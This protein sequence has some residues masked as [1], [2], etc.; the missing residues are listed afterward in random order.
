[1]VSTL[2]K[3][4]CDGTSPIQWTRL[5]LRRRG[6]LRISEE[7]QCRANT[8][9]PRFSH[10]PLKALEFPPRRWASRGGARQDSVPSNA[11]T[12]AS[13]RT[14]HHHGGLAMFG[15]G[16]RF[17]PRRFDNL[18]ESILGILHAFKRTNQ[19]RADSVTVECRRSPGSTVR[20]AEVDWGTLKGSGR[21]FGRP[22]RDRNQ[23]TFGFGNRRR[24]VHRRERRRSGVRLRKR[25][26]N[27]E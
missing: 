15:H 23:N 4:S 5:R 26:L 25:Q 20:R 17:A 14:N 21:P 2:T 27:K 3:R 8:S 18:T 12:C 9:E 19:G 11:A 1:M 13:V 24:G 6:G 10:S 16:L 22:R 7:R